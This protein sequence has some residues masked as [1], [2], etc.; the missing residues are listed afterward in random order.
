[1]RGHCIYCGATVDFSKGEGDHV[2]PAALGLFRGFPQFR[3]ICRSCNNS[4]GRLEEQILRCGPEAVLRRAAHATSPRSRGRSSIA[5]AGSDGA[6]APKFTADLNGT[7]L[8]VHPHPNDVNTVTSP[9]QMVVE[10]QD[11]TSEHVRLNPQMTA[12]VLR[13]K[14]MRYPH[15]RRILLHCEEAHFSTYTA[16][17]RDI[18]PRSTM[19]DGVRME[20]GFHKRKGSI[21]TIVTT[22]Y[23]RALAKIAFHYY[24]IT[25]QRGLVGTEPAFEP[26]R[27][28]ITE[29]GSVDAFFTR[30]M[31]RVELPFRDVPTGGCY[32]PN[33][34]LH[35]IFANERDGRM[36]VG[37]ALFAGPGCVPNTH[38]VTLRPERSTILTARDL[39]GHAFVYSGDDGKHCGHCDPMPNGFLLRPSRESSRTDAGGEL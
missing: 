26:L 35:C 22:P 18:F 19:H 25:N 16:L 3:A 28:F 13:A 8:L 5:W 6:P 4:I 34:W 7:P 11:G 15:R 23:F 31:D 24:L 20:V 9:E 33:H 38:Y 10:M 30:P 14:L 1:M 17:M 39:W 37:V 27:R 2:I 21:R 32:S 12:A 29:D 36:V